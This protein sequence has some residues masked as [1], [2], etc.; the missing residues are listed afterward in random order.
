M[1]VQETCYFPLNSLLETHDF[2]RRKLSYLL[3]FWSKHLLLKMNSECNH[4]TFQVT[5]LE[6]YFPVFRSAC[7]N[8]ITLIRH[9]KH[10]I[11]LTVLQTSRTNPPVHPP[12]KNNNKHQ[13]F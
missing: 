1:D 6:N 4:G 12:Y 10:P 13:P 9:S 11:S 5:I 2:H 3:Y 7:K 8:C